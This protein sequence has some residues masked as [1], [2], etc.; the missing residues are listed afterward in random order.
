MKKA[1]IHLEALESDLRLR[2]AESYPE[3]ILGLVLSARTALAVGRIEDTE[4]LLGAGVKM[5]EKAE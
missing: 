4:L 5:A 3:R 2:S 1:Q